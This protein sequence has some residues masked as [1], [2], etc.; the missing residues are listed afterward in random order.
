MN[1]DPSSRRPSRP[2]ARAAIRSGAATAIASAMAII[3][4]CSTALAPEARAQTSAPR[5]AAQATP[6]F[7]DEGDVAAWTAGGSDGVAASA[8]RAPGR[9]AGATDHAVR[10]NFNFKRGSGYATLRRELDVPVAGNFR[11]VFDVV[12]QSGD[13]NF[14]VKFIDESG[15]DVWWVNQ[16]EFAFPTDWAELVIPRRKL[17]FAWG[18]T[19]GSKPL[20]RIKAIELAVT[21]GSGTS[22]G[23]T[24]WVTIDNV[25]IEALPDVAPPGPVRVSTT[26]TAPGT[27]VDAGL[28]ESAAVRWQPA[29]DDK[30]PQMTLDFGGPRE[31]ARI[32][33]AADLPADLQVRVEALEQG[34]V[35]AQ[36]YAAANRPALL[37]VAGMSPD[38]VRVHGVSAI[39]GVSLRLRD[40]EFLTDPNVTA[41]TLAREGFRASLPRWASGEQS[42]WTIVGKPEEE[43]EFCISED[44]VVELGKAGPGI[45]PSLEANGRVIGWEDATITHRLPT[46]SAP[47]PTVEWRAGDIGLEITA[48][49]PV[50]EPNVAMRAQ[51]KL[52]N[53]GA[54]PWSGALRLSLRPLQAMPAT[55]NLNMTGGA[56]RLEDVAVQADRGGATLS[57]RAKRGTWTAHVAAY[58]PKVQIERI[59]SFRL[60]PSEDAPGFGLAS[61]SFEPGTLASAVASFA[62]TLQP[63]A[64]ERFE[65]WVPAPGADDASN[66][67]HRMQWSDGSLGRTL[68]YWDEQTSRVRFDL[69]PS[70]QRWSEAW[71][72]QIAYILVNRDGPAIQPGS[73]SYDRT[74][75]RDGALTSTALLYSGHAAEVR[76]FIDWFAPFQYDNGKVPCCADERGPDP[77]PEHDSHGQYIYGVA[78]YDRFVRDD[79]FVRQHLPRVKKAVE[80]IQFLRAQRLTD[81]YRNAEG[82]KGAK[83]GLVPES[84]SHEGYSAKPMHSY[85]D[86]FW[87]LRGLEDAAYLGSR[88]GDDAFAQQARTLA[89]EFRTSLYDSMRLAMR[90]TNVDYIPGCVELGD[91]DPTSTSIGVFPV[92][93]LGNIPEPQ[94]TRTFERYIDWFDERARGGRAWKD[95]TPYE[96]RNTT[97]FLFLGRR[98]VTLRMMDFLFADMRPQGWNA[99]AEVVR[100][101]YRTPGF[102]GDIPH[103]WVGSDYV[104]L[105]R[106]MFVHESKPGGL[107]IGLG[108]PDAWIAETGRVGVASAP[109]H[110]GTLG[111]VFERRG[112]DTAIVFDGAL[113]ESP[114]YVEIALERATSAARVTADGKDVARDASGR[115]RLAWP[116]REVVLHA[117]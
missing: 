40:E 7:L 23:G 46:G 14:E 41:S 92:G 70:A 28:S 61:A 20:S 113:R 38:A 8:S 5:A 79:A 53:H 99:W 49:A 24:G 64:T 34:R 63:G 15:E 75:I 101:G 32:D 45:E 42:Y 108:V 59:G 44:G 39:R 66:A 18:P 86:C 84:I 114:A 111:V 13:N 93:E 60:D 106:T 9:S 85:W 103:T 89:G 109:T 102:I 3:A 33:L 37:D 82:L 11:V 30:Q 26:S 95:Y 36:A 87:V 78:E 74:W 50:D 1:P 4:A 94:L 29:P 100:N 69:P 58:Q 105:L 77:V 83:F 104:K 21:V 62:C 27:T 2:R 68:M 35:I 6:L 112:D 19:H 88:A 55:Q 67:A 57:A 117:R 91:Y 31:A 97:T 73:R 22:A 10:L 25:R 116:V 71:R 56:L 16:R 110:F 81:E 51:Y 65:L 17:S 43:A 98:D 96:I 54:T 76:Q 72:A 107:V 115:V 47:V 48:W 80:Y 90:L 12:A 52:K